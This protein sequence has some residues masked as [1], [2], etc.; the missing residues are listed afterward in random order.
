MNALLYELVQERNER[1]TL[2]FVAI[3]DSNTTL[4]K[5]AHD[6]QHKCEKLERK[7]VAQQESLERV[8]ASAGSSGFHGSTGSDDDGDA[9]VDKRDD[10]RLELHYAESAALKNERK[11]R[12]ELER[13]EGQLKIHEERHEKDT[14][15]LE[16][17]N[18]ELTEL[19]ALCT[20]HERNISD[21]TDKNEKQ[22]RAL[23]RLAT[24][25][26]DNEE[27]A[28]LAEQQCIGL[29][30]TIRILQEEN[31]NLKKENLR[32][33]TRLIEE[34]NRLSSEVNSLNEMIEQLRKEGE[35]LQSLKKQEEKR[36][37]WFGFS[38][39][40]TEDST[41]KATSSE[42]R[43]GSSVKSSDAY[44]RQL[45]PDNSGKDSRSDDARK[46]VPV[47]VVVPSRPQKI[48][49]A[50]RHEA[51]C[52]RCVS[53]ATDLLATGGSFDG[54]VK[55]W[56]VSDGSMVAT[57]RGGSSNSIA[58]CDVTKNLVAGG[59]N[60]KTC[61][62]WDIST[63][64]MV[65]QLV[66]H[67]NKIT[68]VKFL[69]GG[70]GIVT[71]SKDRQIKVWDISKQTYRQTTNIVLNSTANSVDVAND[72]YTMVSGHTNGSLRFWDIRTGEKNAEIE[73][74]HRSAITSVQFHP[75]DCSKV[76]TNSMD[77]LIKIVD[78]RTCKAIREFSHADFQT[79]YS[80]SSSVFSPDGAYVSAGSS[81]NGFIFVW[82]AK[83]GQLVRR[84]EGGHQNV[85]VCGIAWGRG[86]NCGHQVASADK[87]GKLILWA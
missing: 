57:L 63:Q 25:V 7:V 76:L 75:K 41:G 40:D 67:T 84:L 80:W 83:N 29:K 6:W 51:A 85:G 8:A 73:N 87:A 19:K 31:D 47:S 71:A 60:D 13:L 49:Q 78:I 65:H 50:H 58:T 1:E 22:E 39:S 2:P 12:E 53:A 21:L 38:V 23:Q 16:R 81:S 4:L 11:M 55:I 79:S 54:T 61:R 9:K 28:N 44:K 70:Q 17:I 43:T 45:V 30:D 77:S 36:K 37:S 82:N 59:G 86:G 14:E 3:H 66:G 18:T 46:V 32:F 34:K 26:S 15:D 64:R 33:E 68:C 48:I 20:A 69:V 27:R 62:V 56:N 52:V 35:M 42:T 5:E 72:T 74:V 10:Q 24:Q